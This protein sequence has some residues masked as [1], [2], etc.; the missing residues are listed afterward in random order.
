MLK[1]GLF[2]AALAGASV[3]AMPAAAQQARGKPIANQ[4]VCAFHEGAVSKNLVRVAAEGAARSNGGRVMHIYDTA[5]SGF[6]VHMSDAAMK[7]MMRQNPGI[8]SCEADKIVSLGPIDVSPKAPP[9]APG[10][11]DKGGSG[12]GGTAPQTD[13]VP[14]GIARVGGGTATYQGTARAFVIDSGVDLDHIELNVVGGVDFTGEGNGGDDRNGHGTHVAGTIGAKKN[15]I[16]V[17]GVAPGAPIFAVRVLDASGSGS[18][19]NVIA[20]V[21][22]VAENGKS[23]D[24]ANMSL[25][26]PVDS[27]L[28]T[29]VENAASLG[30]RFVLAAGNERSDTATTSPASTE[31]PNVYTIAA[32]DSGDGWARFS[33]YGDEVDFAEP[34]VDILSTYYDD[35][36][37]TM[38]G[39]SMAAPHAAGILLL[40]PITGDGTVYH[41]RSNAYYLIGVA[42]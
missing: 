22:Y 29:A 20:G 15:G 10:K 25:G 16:G 30:I 33:N 9:G 26:G 39:T 5:L 8:A 24:V 34:G 28:N 13:T 21:D 40:G 31:G 6:S 4:F 36:L 42:N 32:T 12:D 2:F 35:R 19:S 11:P 27:L 37:A 41:R 3:I 7:K 38:S 1:K 18:Y 23:G 17:V 14:W